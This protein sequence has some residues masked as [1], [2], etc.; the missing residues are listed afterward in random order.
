MFYV[1]IDFFVKYSLLT[2]LKDKIMLFELINGAQEVLTMLFLLPN[3]WDQTLAYIYK[4]INITLY[5]GRPN[6]IEIH[7]IVLSVTPV[8]A[9]T[10]TVHE[11]PLLI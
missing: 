11:T 4:G 7:N 1:V 10:L 9:L 8:S 6:G 5:S 2:E 3:M